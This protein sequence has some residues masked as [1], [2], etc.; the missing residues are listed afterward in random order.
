M[1]V[2]AIAFHGTVAISK[3][4]AYYGSSDASTLSASRT[5]FCPKCRLTFVAVFKNCAD[6]C[7]ENRL[8]ELRNIVQEDCINGL[9]QE[10]YVLSE[11]E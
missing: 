11:P 2:T 4:K 9:H 10:E 5:F 8:E 3:L 1:P 7:K 6:P